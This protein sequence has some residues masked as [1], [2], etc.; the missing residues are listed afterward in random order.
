MMIPLPSMPWR[1]DADLFFRDRDI[2]V[3]RL[4]KHRGANIAFV[5]AGVG[6]QCGFVPDRVLELVI[7]KKRRNDLRADVNCAG[8]QEHN[9]KTF[10]WCSSARSAGASTLALLVRRL[11]N[12]LKILN[13]GRDASILGLAGRALNHLHPTFGNL[14]ANIDPEGNSH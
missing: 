6:V 10:L 11:Q 3:L 14:L 9:H 13:Y 8:D 1:C 7:L 12:F 2:E 4:A 5:L